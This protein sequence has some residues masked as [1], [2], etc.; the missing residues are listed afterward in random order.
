MFSVFVVISIT[1]LQ[2]II[3]PLFST[4]NSSE[5]F[6]VQHAWSWIHKI[7]TEKRS[8]YHKPWWCHQFLLSDFLPRIYI[9]PYPVDP[10]RLWSASCATWTKV[11]QRRSPNGIFYFQWSFVWVLWTSSSATSDVPPWNTPESN[12]S[13]LVHPPVD[14]V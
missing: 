8:T 11:S 3:I 2:I 13:L 1:I 6:S 14:V 5:N 10:H 9:D 4:K 7:R 12:S